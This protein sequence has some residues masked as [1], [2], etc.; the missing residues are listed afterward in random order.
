[1]FA[2]VIVKWVREHTVLPY[3]SDRTDIGQLRYPFCPP[4]I[5]HYP[6]SIQ[7]GTEIVPFCLLLRIFLME[8]K[9]GSLIFLNKPEMREATLSVSE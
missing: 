2:Q 5:L 8:I 6:F 9:L 1:M 7:K 4:F 3:K